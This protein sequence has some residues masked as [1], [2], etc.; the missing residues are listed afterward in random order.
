MTKRGEFHPVI[1]S[2]VGNTIDGPMRCYLRM[3]GR[4]TVQ[5]LRDHLAAH[6]PHVDFDQVALNFG[7]AVWERPAHAQEIEQRKEWQ[8][9]QAERTEAWERRKYTELKAKYEPAREESSTDT[10][11]DSLADSPIE[12]YSTWRKVKPAPAP[13]EECICFVTPESQWTTHYDATEP[14]S[15]MEPNPEC[16]VHFPSAPPEEAGPLRCDCGRWIPC[17]HCPEPAPHLFT[18]DPSAQHGE[19]CGLCG[20]QADDYKDNHGSGSE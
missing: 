16:R 20:L 7:T 10:V 12:D 14:G 3:E 8:R 9:K 4:V 17:R 1:C 13:R 15:T 6:Y 19:P 5:Q 11:Y 18:L 2:P